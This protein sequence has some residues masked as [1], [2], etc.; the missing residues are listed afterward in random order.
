MPLTADF[1]SRLRFSLC[2]TSFSFA[3]PVVPAASSSTSGFPQGPPQRPPP[4]TLP[5]PSQPPPLR[6]PSAFANSIAP[7]AALAPVAANAAGALPPHVAYMFDNHLAAA[8]QSADCVG[9]GTVE[10]ST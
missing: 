1:H 5:P 6:I 4:R 8:V 7:T 2:D 9:I 10:A 3:A